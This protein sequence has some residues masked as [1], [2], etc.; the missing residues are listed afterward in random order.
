M[1][2]LGFKIK[3][4][5]AEILYLI[6]VVIYKLINNLSCE[7]W[8]FEILFHCNISK[9]HFLQHRLNNKTF[10]KLYCFMYKT[11]QMSLIEKVKEKYNFSVG[12]KAQSYVNEFYSRRQSTRSISAKVK[13]N[14]GEYLASLTLRGQ[15]LKPACSCYV[16]KYGCHHTDALAFTYLQD[17]DSFTLKKVKIQP[18]AKTLEELKHYLDNVSLEELIIQLKKKGISQKAFAESI[19][20]KTSHLSAVKRAESRNRHFHELGAIKLACVWVLEKL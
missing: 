11:K 3:T 2:D 1:L 13:G 19:N 12:T 17:P 15:S 10:V 6:S 20:M 8:G 7:K 5:L 18:N 14:Y 9:L 4:E 16:G